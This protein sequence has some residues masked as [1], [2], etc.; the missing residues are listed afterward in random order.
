VSENRKLNKAEIHYLQPL[1]GSNLS[2]LP[3]DSICCKK[4]EDYFV[5]N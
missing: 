3:A 5:G 4:R 1:P 2:F